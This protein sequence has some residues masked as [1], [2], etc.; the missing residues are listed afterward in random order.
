MMKKLIFLVFAVVAMQVQAQDETIFGIKG[1]AN[2]SNLKSIVNS[3]GISGDGSTSVFIGGFADFWVAEMLH[4]Q[5]ELQFSIEGSENTDITYL[6]IPVIFKYYVLEGLNIQAGPQL[7]FL[8]DAEGGTDDFK[9]LN[10]VLDFGAGFELPGGFL[11]EGRYNLGLTDIS[12][13]DGPFENV[14]L[15]T[16]GFQLGVGYRF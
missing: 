15:K 10:F 12:E 13:A 3:D 4:L 1:G 6:N 8:L 11:V 7:G 16:K 14:K 9:A 2:F 5:P